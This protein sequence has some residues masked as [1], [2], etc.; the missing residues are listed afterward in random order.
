MNMKYDEDNKRIR[1]ENRRDAGL[2]KELKKTQDKS[3]GNNE[4]NR[5]D[6]I[7]SDFGKAIED[8][9]RLFKDLGEENKCLKE[10]NE[11]KNK[12]FREMSSEI[13]RLGKEN[14]S[15]SDVNKSLEKENEHL[16]GEFK[17]IQE[18]LV[19]KKGIIMNL[20]K[21]KEDLKEENK[22]LKEKKKLKFMKEEKVIWNNLNLDDVPKELQNDAYDHKVNGDINGW[23]WIVPYEGYLRDF[24][25]NEMEKMQVLIAK[26][27][28]IYVSVDKN[29]HIIYIEKNK[30]THFPI[31]VIRPR[32]MVLPA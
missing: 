26:K 29:K 14:Q 19:Q 32:L 4:K 9:Q 5:D 17:E 6:I 8:L 23:Y 13:E 22:H 16:K 2:S 25:Q 18:I 3:N 11:K 28:H 10:E 30:Y 21:E 7:L 20:E 27:R 15:L 1:D 24:T 12:K 31:K